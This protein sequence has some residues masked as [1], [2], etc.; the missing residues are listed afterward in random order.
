MVEGQG[1]RDGQKQM[2]TQTGDRVWDALRASDI[3]GAHLVRRCRIEFSRRTGPEKQTEEEGQEAAW[4]LGRAQRTE[5]QESLWG[6]R[7]GKFLEGHGLPCQ[8]PQ[9][10]SDL[11]PNTDSVTLPEELLLCVCVCTAG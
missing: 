10:P 7:E 4:G 3:P 8:G 11:P 1:L 6:S 5:D 2:R 9:T